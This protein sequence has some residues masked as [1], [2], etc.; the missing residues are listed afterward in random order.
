MIKQ[1]QRQA[2]A[3]IGLHDSGVSTSS[4]YLK[5]HGKENLPTVATQMERSS[6]KLLSSEEE[7]TDRDTI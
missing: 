4:H 3:P 7:D 6:I 2:T 1:I 5:M